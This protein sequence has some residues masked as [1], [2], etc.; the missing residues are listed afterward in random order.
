[1]GGDVQLPQTYQ[2]KNTKC[3]YSPMHHHN[4]WALKYFLVIEIKKHAQ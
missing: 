1:M 3:S 2:G 4:R